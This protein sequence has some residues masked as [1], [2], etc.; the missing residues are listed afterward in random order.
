MIYCRLPVVEATGK[1]DK[2]ALPKFNLDK[3]NGI[4]MD[5]L[6]TQTEKT[7]MTIF[8]RALKTF[9][10]DVQDNFFENGGWVYNYLIILSLRY[11]NCIMYK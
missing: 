3:I 10:F 1:L 2:S 9:S 6:K 11:I 4:L 7:V 5:N 8:C